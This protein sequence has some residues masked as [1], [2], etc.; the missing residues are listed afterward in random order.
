[1]TKT[2]LKSQ[3]ALHIL[4][5]IYKERYGKEIP[6]HIIDEIIGSDIE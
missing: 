2:V 1:M 5:D 3:D 6:Q 4:T